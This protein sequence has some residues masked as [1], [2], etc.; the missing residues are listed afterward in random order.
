MHHFRWLKLFK[1]ME[2]D[3][4]SY[5]TLLIHSQVDGRKLEMNMPDPADQ[6]IQ[7]S[8]LLAARQQS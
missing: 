6:E 5:S 1:K 4:H 3:W 2:E 8:G 7:P